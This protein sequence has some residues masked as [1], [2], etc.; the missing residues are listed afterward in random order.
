MVRYRRKAPKHALRA[1]GCCWLLTCSLICGCGA[2]NSEAVLSIAGAAENFPC[3]G[4]RRLK[5]TAYK[6]EVDG[7]A[8]EVFGEY[9]NTDGSCNLPAGLPLAISDLPLTSRMWILVEGFDSSTKRRMSMGQT[10]VLLPDDVKSGELGELTLQRERVNETYSTVTL[11][12]GELPGLGEVGEIDKVQ[13]ILNAGRPGSVNGSFKLESGKSWTDMEYV[14]SNILPGNGND[15]LVVARKEGSPRASWESE[16][17]DLLESDMFVD[18][19]M[20]RQE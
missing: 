10:D 3:L 16:S 2:E 11:L 4:V 14:I 8:A 19:N 9:Y 12:I 5:I 6:N 15:L 1:A 7:K 17:F 20:T 18:L 13:F